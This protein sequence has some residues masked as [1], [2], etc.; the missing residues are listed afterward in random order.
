[1]QITMGMLISI[2]LLYAVFINVPWESVINAIALLDV[3][4]L[5]LSSLFF[6]L[7][8]L[9]RAIA[10][11][12]INKVQQSAPSFSY[13]FGG[14]MVGYLANNIL[15]LKSGELVR[16]HYLSR[17][18]SISFFHATGTIVVER[19][20]DVIT[21][22]GLLLCLVCLSMEQVVSKDIYSLVL[23]IGGGIAGFI[24]ILYA[25][26]NNVVLRNALQRV[27]WISRMLELLGCLFDKKTVAIVFAAILGS[28]VCNYLSVWVLLEVV[29]AE[30]AKAALL[31]L[32]LVNFSML[33]PASPGA[34]GV[35]QMAFL[36]ALQ[37]F[38]VEAEQAVALSFGYQAGF[39]VASVLFGIPYYL[40]SGM[41]F[42]A[43]AKNEAN[44]KVFPDG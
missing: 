9:F 21:L 23:L 16:A 12:F 29:E 39:Y 27:P 11:K 4:I 14:V 26:R 2:G 18:G 20:F 1:M 22:F 33:I 44:S 10:W 8:C 17:T 31:L 34:F 43:F 36:V 37:P 7:G 6:T 38:G 15:P 19:F 35:L 24:G 42:S 13:L 32:V 40:Y 25:S 28:W 30:R 3:K 41:K 5:G